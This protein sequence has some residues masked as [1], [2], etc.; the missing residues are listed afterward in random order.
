MTDETPK[1]RHQRLAR[2]WK[3]EHDAANPKHVFF[4][5]ACL[6]AMKDHKEKAEAL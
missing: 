5:E 1:Q 2:E 6:V 4:R 3:R